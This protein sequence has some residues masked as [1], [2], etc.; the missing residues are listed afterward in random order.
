[1]QL[2]SKMIGYFNSYAAGIPIEIEQKGSTII[3]YGSELA[4]LR[5]YARWT[6]DKKTHGYS[7]HRSSFYFRLDLGY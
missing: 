5:I 3:V 1:M 6:S 4:T 7:K 2:T